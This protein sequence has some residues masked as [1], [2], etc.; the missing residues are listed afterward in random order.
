MKKKLA[1]LIYPEFSLQEVSNLIYLFRWNYDTVTDVIYTEREPVKSEEGIVVMPVKTC[2]EFCV[3]EYD[4]LVLPGCSDTRMALGNIKLKEFLKSL[5]NQNDFVIGAI[6]SAPLFLAQ[7]GL[8]KGKK[9]TDSLFVEMR[10]LFP[11]IEAGNFMPKPV[12]EDG[13]IITANGSA[14]NDFAVHLAR[15]LGY[16][17]QDRIL[18]GYI[19]NWTKEDYFAHLPEE[20]VKELEEEFSD[21]LERVNEK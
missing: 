7:A 9:Y 12:V 21:F 4:C 11:F 8:L 15:K 10:E 18:S 20:D 2:S 6:C 16:E 5:Q 19:E 3:E 13:N 14:F 17:C 1:L